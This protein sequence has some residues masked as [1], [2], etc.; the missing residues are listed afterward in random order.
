MKKESKIFQGF[1]CQSKQFLCKFN[2]FSAKKRKKMRVIILS[3][4]KISMNS[5]SD[6]FSEGYTYNGLII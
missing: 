3:I 1:G 2:K 4:D 6:V 5:S